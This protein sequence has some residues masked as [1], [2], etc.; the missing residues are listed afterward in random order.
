MKRLKQIKIKNLWQDIVEAIG[1]TEQDF[2][3]GSLSRAIF[4]LSVPM[5]LEMIMESVFAIADIF[6]VSKLGADAVATIGITESIM[7]LVYAIAAG[8]STA[9]TALVA[10]R[11]GEKNEKAAAMA[12]VQAILLGTLVST[13]LAIPGFIWAK[14]VLDLMGASE[15]MVNGGYMY[16]TIMFGGNLVIMLLFIINA[17]FRGAGDAAISMRVL[18]FANI[19]NIILD[20]CLI[21]GLG[22]FPELGIKGAALATN[23]GRGSAVVYQL[24]LLLN[25]KHRVKIKMEYFKLQFNIL[26]SLIKISFGG[27]GQHIIA[28]SSWIFMVRV[29]SLF[30]NFA[31]AGYTIAIRI[32]V[33]ALLPSWGLSNAASTLVGQN[34]GAKQAVRAEKSVWATS[35]SN[36]IFMG[37]IGIILVIFPQI[38]IKI[39]INEPAVILKGISSLRIISYGF[40]FYGL[41]MVMAQAFNGAGDTKTPTIINLICFWLIEIPLAYS[42]A[43][44]LGLNENGVYIAIIISESLMALMGYMIFKQGKWKTREV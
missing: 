35:I 15:K 20:P 26:K 41:G 8:L 18:W 11:I 27:I 19:I 34:L 38:F 30:G 3:T 21:F 39:F 37:I 10:R 42:L 5:V 17:V 23:I 12:A 6:F 44:P 7:T 9:T 33:F 22:P 40:V 4:L 24:F 28:T 13:F 32:V 31:L 25:G 29:I 43:I 1:G 36:M 2:T 16:P 14:K